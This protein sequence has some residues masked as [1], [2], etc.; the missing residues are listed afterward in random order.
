MSGDKKNDRDND[1]DSGSAP[2]Q[3]SLTLLCL[4]GHPGSGKSTLARALARQLRW[5]LLDKDD[6]KDHIWSLADGNDLAYAILW[7]MTAT[8][9]SL[10]LSVI[11]DSPLARPQLY[12]RVSEIAQ[13]YS[14]RLLIVQ[15]TLTEADWR[16]RLEERRTRRS[17]HKVSDWD[18]MERLL[19]DYNDSWRY[20][21]AA[22]HLLTLDTT[23]PVAELV[24]QVAMSVKTVWHS[25][26]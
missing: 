6:I 22:E 5:P 2:I 11:V 15:T 7:Q 9:L 14:A 3:A 20:P 16:R 21:I 17:P 13:Q 24:R 26:T 8:Q 19:V 1:N 25:S 18:E 10:G 12:A 23:R 4:K